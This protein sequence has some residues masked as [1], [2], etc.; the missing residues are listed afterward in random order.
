MHKLKH[1][2]FPLE[3]SQL[4]FFFFQLP[5][6]SGEYL[7]NLLKAM[8]S[9]CQLL[10]GHNSCDLQYRYNA[11]DCMKRTVKLG[12]LACIKEKKN[13]LNVIREVLQSTAFL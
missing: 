4:F 9:K 3:V 6:L 5:N 10:G 7:L 8:G 13:H 2:M 1:M 11:C 12:T